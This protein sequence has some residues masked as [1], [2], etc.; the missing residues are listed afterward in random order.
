M[1]NLLEYKRP[2]KPAVDKMPL[3]RFQDRDGEILETIYSYGGVLARRQ[4]KELFWSYKSWR[5]ME[6]RLAKLYHNRLIDWP[7]RTQ[8]RTKPVAEPVIWLGWKGIH[9]LAGRGG[10]QVPAPASEGENQLRI[11]EKRL[12]DAGIHWLREPRWMQLEHD[13]AVIDFRLAVEEG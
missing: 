3:M 13:L 10:I 9:W 11:F 8:W 5:A 1:D 6:K 12:R 2:L 7:T 4:L